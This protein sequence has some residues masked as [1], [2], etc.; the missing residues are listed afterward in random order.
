MAGLFVEFDFNTDLIDAVR[1]DD[2]RTVFALL[3]DGADADAPVVIGH[4]VSPLLQ[5]KEQVGYRHRELPRS[6]PLLEMFRQRPNTTTS[7]VRARPGIPYYTLTTAPDENTAI[8]SALL[9][10]QIDVN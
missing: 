3:R 8:L 10:C 4:P 1:R 2:T 5:L 9:A 7:R 6:S